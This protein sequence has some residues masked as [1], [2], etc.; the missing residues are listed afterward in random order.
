MSTSYRWVGVES[1]VIGASSITTLA[2]TMPVTAT[3]IQYLVPGT[4]RILIPEPEEQQ[5]ECEDTTEPDVIL[6]DDAAKTVE[7]G[8]RDMGLDMWN[9]GF[10]GASSGSDTWKAP[11]TATSLRTKS[12]KLVTKPIGGYKYEFHIPKASLVAGANLTLQNKSPESGAIN[13]RGTIMQ[14]T[15]PTGVKVPP[16]KV[17]RVAE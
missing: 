14:G 7:F 2:V 8:T 17:V 16:Y 11:T 6:F 1:I 3:S 5:L 9:L 15:T 12:L 10:G 4:A 13:F